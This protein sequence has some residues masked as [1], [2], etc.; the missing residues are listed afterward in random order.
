MWYPCIDD[1][2]DRAIYD[3]YITVQQQYSAICGGSILET[4]DNGNSTYTY[5]WRLNNEIPTYLASVAVGTY[6]AVTDTFNGQLGQVPVYLYVRPQD[7][8]K[9]NASFINL[10]EVFSAYESYFG[11]YRWERVGFT[12]IPFNS[13]AMEHATNIGYPQFAIDGSLTYEDLYAHE[14]AHHWFGNLITCSTAEDMWINEGGATYCE[15]I[16]TQALYGAAQAKI[17]IRNTQY[18]VLTKAHLDDGGYY[19]LSGIPHEI[20]YGT[21][22]YD[23]GAMAFH[24]IRNY[25][26]DSIFFDAIKNFMDLRGF[27]PVSSY[28]LRDFLTEYTSIDMTPFFDVWIFTPGFL[29]YSIDSFVVY[30]DSNEW[31]TTTVYVRQKLFERT[32]FADANRLQVGFL[33]SGWNIHLQTIE[34]DGQYGTASFSSFY[35]PLL[36]MADPEEKTADATVDHYQ[37]I[38]TTGYTLFTKAGCKVGVTAISDSAF[39]RAEHNFVA[40]DTFKVPHDGM[41]LSNNHYWKID[42][43][44]TG[45]INAKLQLEYNNISGTGID[46][47]LLSDSLDPDSALR[48]FYRINPA[49]DWEEINFTKSGSD[50]YGFLIT[51]SLLFGEYSLAVYD[52]LRYDSLILWA[53]DILKT[54]K[55]YSLSV[56]PNPS[57]NE[58]KIICSAKSTGELLISNISGNTILRRQVPSGN[59]TFIWRPEG[60]PSG[61]YNILLYGNNKD[62]VITKVIYLKK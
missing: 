28:D 13:G 2:V 54:N 30:P 40:P 35:N 29:H 62:S 61:V 36:V 10:N 39:V 33:D 51:E 25:L 41:I 26:G 21:T 3:C 42:G 15:F 48:L 49:F 17:N 38:K 55:T 4:V 12:S 19:P 16:Y 43:V 11:P 27:S 1:F 32:I 20:T 57:S 53:G 45:T 8:Q 23:K 52:T 22:V 6:T 59:S 14:F 50:Y 44:I 58:F 56:F 47:E 37:I 46:D 24:T 9:A 18:N 5:H 60:I 31:F 7:V 34:F